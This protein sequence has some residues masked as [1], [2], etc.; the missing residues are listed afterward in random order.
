LLKI[1]IHVAEAG[2]PDLLESAF[3]AISAAQTGALIVLRRGVFRPVP[4][5]GGIRRIRAPADKLLSTA[6]EVIE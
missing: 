1:E 2:A 4:A 5:R 3:A 6:D